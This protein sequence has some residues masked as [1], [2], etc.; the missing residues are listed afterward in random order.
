MLH[1]GVRDRP[2][3]LDAGR[4]S[5]PGASSAAVRS[6]RALDISPVPRE[7]LQDERR[8]GDVRHKYRA[9]SST[10][11]LPSLPI[12]NSGREVHLF[13][14]EA[15]ATAFV[16]YSAT[17]QRTLL[18]ATNHAKWFFENANVGPIASVNRLEC[19]GALL[20][21]HLRYCRPEG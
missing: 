3:R 6:W 10:R 4:A 20:K 16:K 5:L 12:D 2:Q 14:A 8:F 1:D 19:D 17:T 13:A 9:C 15:P 21:P 7:F 11:S 18:R